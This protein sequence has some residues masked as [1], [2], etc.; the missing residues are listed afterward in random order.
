MR[1][2]GYNQD[3]EVG[4]LG[5]APTVLI[6]TFVVADRGG[7]PIGNIGVILPN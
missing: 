6:P 4:N 7:L 2:W 3:G 5:N 1:C